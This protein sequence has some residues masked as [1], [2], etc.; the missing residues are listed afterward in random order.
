[1]AADIRDKEASMRGL[2]VFL[3]GTV[4]VLMTGMVLGK[5][6]WLACSHEAVGRRCVEI[7][8][9]QC[10]SQDAAYREAAARWRHGQP[11]H[12]RYCLLQR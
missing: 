3:A 7:G 12:W 11:H 1:V 6:G 10:L 9:G 2:A 5:S 8:G 4:A